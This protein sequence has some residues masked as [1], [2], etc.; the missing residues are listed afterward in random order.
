MAE[1]PTEVYALV[2][3][4]RSLFARGYSFGT[5]GNLSVRC[6]D[7]VY[8]T[9]TGSSFGTLIVEAMA[10]CD[11]AGTPL[12]VQRATKELAFHLAA[13]RARSDA[14]AVVHLHSTYATAV[15][16]LEELNEQDALPPMTPY[17]AMRIPSLPTVRYLPPGDAGLAGEVE[18]LA[19]ISPAMLMRNHGAITLGR[20]IAEAAA[21]AEEVE[22]TA[23]LYLLLGPRAR[24]LDEEQVAE[25]RRRF[26]S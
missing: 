2:A 9:P 7:T 19:K 17:F 25:L 21:L 13:Y 23:K 22:E 8:A 18:R 26:P 20:N 6:G 11:L 3:M 5:A 14:R 1:Y 16:C 10:A 12:S 15:A 24:P 4:A